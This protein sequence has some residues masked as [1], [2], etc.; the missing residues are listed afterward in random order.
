MSDSE[1]DKVIAVNEKA[2]HKGKPDNVTS[3]SAKSSPGEH[4]VDIGVSGQNRSVIKSPKGKSKRKAKKSNSKKTKKRKISPVSSS[5]S[6]DS[7]SDGE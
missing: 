6:E 5:S 2:K 1:K 3:K 7:G 4:V